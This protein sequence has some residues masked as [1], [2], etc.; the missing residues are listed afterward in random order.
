MRKA[1]TF[2]TAFLRPSESEC[3][4]ARAR[5]FIAC[6]KKLTRKSLIIRRQRLKAPTTVRDDSA[7]ADSFGAQ[8]MSVSHLKAEHFAGDIES[9][10]LAPTVAEELAGPNNAR[11]ELEKNIGGAAFAV[12]VPILGKM[13]HWPDRAQCASGVGGA[14]SRRFRPRIRCR[15]AAGCRRRDFYQEGEG[16]CSGIPCQRMFPKQQG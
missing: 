6:A 11:H 5:F 1:A 10:Y 15:H 12:N 8:A 16:G 3:S 14:R 9:V 13:Q 2:S 7:I 4:W